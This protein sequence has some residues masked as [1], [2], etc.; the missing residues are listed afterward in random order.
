M[1]EMLHFY[2]VSGED[3]FRFYQQNY[4]KAFTDDS[5]LM[6]L[7]KRNLEIKKGFIERD[8]FDRGERLLLNYGTPLV[9]LLKHSQ[10]IQSLT[11]LL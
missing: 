8:E 11:V 2:L 7:I 10:T 6:S 5:A 9:M 1:G 3:D 4:D